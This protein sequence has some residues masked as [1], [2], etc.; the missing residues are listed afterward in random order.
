MDLKC[1]ICSSEDLFY[2][3]TVTFSDGKTYRVYKCRECGALTKVLY[4]AYL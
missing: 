2:K 4:A 1:C 3:D